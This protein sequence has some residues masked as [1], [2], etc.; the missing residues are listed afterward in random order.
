M[1]KYRFSVDG[2]SVSILPVMDPDYPRENILLGLEKGELGVVLLP[3]RDA[4]FRMEC[5]DKNN[6]EPRE[7]HVP[8]AALSCFFKRV[9]GYP[10][11]KINIAYRGKEYEI[12]LDDLERHK[13]L[14]NSGKC[15]ILY[16]KNIEFC[17]SIDISV[18]IISAGSTYAVACCEDA[19]CFSDARLCLLFD[20]LGTDGV[21]GLILLS[22]ADA[23][24]VKTKGDIPF[25]EALGISDGVLSLKVGHIPIGEHTAS[26]NGVRHCFSRA[27]GRLT[28]YPEIKYIS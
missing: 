4:D 12:R 1:E 7:P 27:V 25:Y 21:R 23:L 13:F 10:N 6:S 18:D 9:R 28:L 3:D 15:K 26:V 17:D 20:R 11:M 8:L 2:I 5:F 16:T 14:I 22:L 19:E 24:T